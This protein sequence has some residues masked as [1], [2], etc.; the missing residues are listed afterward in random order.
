MDGPERLGE[1]LS[2]RRFVDHKE[3]HKRR[4]TASTFIRVR[5][6]KVDAAL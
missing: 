6:F 3:N 4:K 5:S 1:Q 2:P